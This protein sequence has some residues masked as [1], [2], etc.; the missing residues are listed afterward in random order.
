[1]K[2]SFMDIVS[3]PVVIVAFLGLLGIIVAQIV[4][5]WGKKKDTD[6]IAMQT[7]IAFLRAEYERL[8][9][10]V[11]SMREELKSSR[12][13]ERLMKE[14]YSAALAYAAS[15]RIGAMAHFAFLDEKGVSHGTLPVLS[16]LIEQDLLQTWPDAGD[17]RL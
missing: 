5:I 3:N 12:L 2:P 10:E 4:A 9:K 7:N 15:L 1:M 11:E 6:I 13:T 17:P 16:P 8:I 14:K